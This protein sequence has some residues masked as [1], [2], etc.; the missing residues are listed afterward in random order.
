MGL[1][2]SLTRPHPP[3]VPELISCC[4]LTLFRFSGEKSLIEIYISV[5]GAASALRGLGRRRTLKISHFQLSNVGKHLSEIFITSCQGLQRQRMWWWQGY[6]E[7]ALQ[8]VRKSP[9]RAVITARGRGAVMCEWTSPFINQCLCSGAAV[10]V[11]WLLP[12]HCWWAVLSLRSQEQKWD[13]NPRQDKLFKLG[14]LGHLTLLLCR[15]F[16]LEDMASYP[17]ALQ[18]AFCSDSQCLVLKYWVWNMEY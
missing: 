15:L 6:C 5:S 17:K 16:P 13:L 18:R 1:A 7:V 4:K 12:W 14:D 3:P 8:W 9:A 2:V 11:L 10:T